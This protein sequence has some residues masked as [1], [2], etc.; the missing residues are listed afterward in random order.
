MSIA[1]YAANRPAEFWRPLP[2]AE[3]DAA[4]WDRVPGTS[5]S[6]S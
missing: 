3:P 6:C 1:L 2:A 4:R 5:A